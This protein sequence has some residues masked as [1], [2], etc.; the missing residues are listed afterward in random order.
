MEKIERN[1]Q[2]VSDYL[3]GVSM[4]ELVDKYSLH[5]STLQKILLKYSVKLHKNKSKI[6]CNKNFFILF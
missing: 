3:S 5:R 2:I 6:K 1:L 4:S